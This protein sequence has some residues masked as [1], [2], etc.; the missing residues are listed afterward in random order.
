MMQLREFWTV[1]AKDPPM[2]RALLFVS[3]IAIS[4]LF[5]G[6]AAG[7]ADDPRATQLV[8]HPWTKVCLEQGNSSCFVSARARGGCYPSGGE[9]SIAPKDDKSRMLA[10]YFGTKQMLES[11]SVQIDQDPILV[12]SP[13]CD[14]HACRA[15]VEIDGEFIDRMKLSRIITIETTAEAHKKISFSF[16]LADFA[17]AYDGPGTEAPKMRV[18]VV[19]SEKMKEL[20]EQAEKQKAFEC[21]D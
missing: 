10:T 3:L 9:I 16:S 18:E 1:I 6:S 5:A 21:A 19:T 7:A 17:K 2:R 8:Y 20:K 13:A 14:G 12:V 15:K 11:I 4:T